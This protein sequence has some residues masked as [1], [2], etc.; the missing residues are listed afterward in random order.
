MG[1]RWL[2]HV[3]LA[4]RGA[5]RGCDGRGAQQGGGGGEKPG[6]GERGQER[7]GGGGGA[8]R[9]KRRKTGA[10]RGRRGKEEGYGDNKYSDNL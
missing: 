1:P 6:A 10:E 2:P 8:R 9:E 7:K 3:D 4:G 5:E